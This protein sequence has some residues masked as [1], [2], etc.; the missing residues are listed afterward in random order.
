M[1]R[2]TLNTYRHYVR[3]VV[4]NPGQKPHVILAKEACIQGDPISMFLYEIGLL[5]LAERLRA[6]HD[7]VACPFFADDLT[8][9]GRSRAVAGAMKTVIT[10]G[11]SLGYYA[12]AAKS[13]VICAEWAEGAA[14]EQ[15]EAQGLQI[16]YTRGHRYVGGFVG[17]DAAERDWVEPQVK[18]WVEGVESLAKVA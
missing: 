10:Y 6:D 16:Q 12:A 13:W 15:M 11:P 14:R 8:L 3:M 1:A 7:T 5:P 18:T 17:S 9:A 2:F 4:R